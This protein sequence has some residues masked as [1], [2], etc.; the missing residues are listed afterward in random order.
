M[1]KIELALARAE[2][3]SASVDMATLAAE[4]RKLRDES[5]YYPCE[6]GRKIYVPGLVGIADRDE[7]A[8]AVVRA[9][10]ATPFDYEELERAVGAL[11]RA[12][13]DGGRDR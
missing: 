7:A 1:N 4:V 3:G 5:P 10:N 8:A 6:C 12:L 13:A 9:W 11:A 2:S